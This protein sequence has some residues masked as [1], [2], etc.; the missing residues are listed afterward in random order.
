MADELAV[1]ASITDVTHSI[2]QQDR[3][4]G[5][6]F[7]TRALTGEF[8]FPVSDA[9][10]C[11]MEVEIR[12]DDQ[13]TLSA[14]FAPTV[15]GNSIGGVS[16]TLTRTAGQS[17]SFKAK[18]CQRCRLYA[19]MP[20]AT[21]RQWQVTSGWGPWRH[22]AE[23]YD[24][25][26]DETIYSPRCEVNPSC[27]G[28]TGRAIPPDDRPELHRQ[29]ELV[30]ARSYRT[31]VFEASETLEV[32]SLAELTTTIASDLLI[33]PSSQATVIQPL[34]GAPVS[35]PRRSQL[36]DLDEMV[37]VVPSLDAVDTVIGGAR[38]REGNVVPISAIGFGTGSVDATAQLLGVSNEPV[39]ER[40]R[41]FSNRLTESLCIVWGLV[42]IP[43]EARDPLRDL[44]I[45]LEMVPT[46]DGPPGAVAFPVRYIDT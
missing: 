15:M 6:R 39:A 23:D 3:K 1:D 46:E 45:S 40:A 28:C 21:L 43:E 29:R 18:R 8:C 12:K 32:R 37:I 9:F 22:I 38:V 14:N 31:L 13:L 25:Q 34:L 4:N 11:G 30:A 5:R 33:S 35:V 20:N 2:P 44:R 36:A 42:E 19:C 24:I 17:M 26:A 10:E 27:P 16:V 7:L 41:L